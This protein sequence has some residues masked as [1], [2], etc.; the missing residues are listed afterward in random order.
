MPTGA[1]DI[2]FSTTDCEC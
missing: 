2:T 1:A